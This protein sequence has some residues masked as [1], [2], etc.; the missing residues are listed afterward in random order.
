MSRTPKTDALVAVLRRRGVEVL[1][2]DQWGSIRRSTYAARLDSRPHALLP[3]RP[4]D[5]LWNHITVTFDDGVLVGDFAADMREV[6]RIGYDRFG[7]GVSYNILIDA[8][9]TRPR[10]AIGQFLEA[11]GTHT[12]NDKGVAGYSY[13][14]NAV[15]LA[16]AW[17]GVPGDRLNE[18]AET[19]LVEVRAAL[20]EIDALTP[21]YDDVPHSLVAAKDCPTN[22]LRDRLPVLKRAALNQEDDMPYTENQLTEIVRA[23]VAAELKGDRERA[24]NRHRKVVERLTTLRKQGKA[25]RADLD[26]LATLLED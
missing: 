5:T 12:V 4:V 21:D 25:T 19:A 20:I 16:V 6:E 9:A 7:S 22:E 14:Q 2:H 23:A 15:A 13:D 1:T 26:D 17:V 18:H 11:K 24:T 3:Q 8:N 10:V